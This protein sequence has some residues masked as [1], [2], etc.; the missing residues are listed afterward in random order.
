MS[1]LLPAWPRNPPSPGN[2][3]SSSDPA[4]HQPRSPCLPRNLLVRPLTSPDTRPGSTTSTSSLR[5][6]RIT[7]DL[8]GPLSLGAPRKLSP[9]PLQLQTPG[10]K[11]RTSRPPSK[12]SPKTPSLPP[13]S[14]N[15]SPFGPTP[16][17]EPPPTPA[18]PPPCLEG[19][20]IE[21]GGDVTTYSLD[22][23]TLSND[24]LPPQNLPQ[25]LTEL[26]QCSVP[27]PANSDTSSA[28]SDGPLTNSD[29]FPA[30]SNASP[31]SPEP[32]GPFPCH[33]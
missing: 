28:N 32:L 18:R 1:T 12:D 20:D 7:Q 3:L 16:P 14:P 9:P 33:A 15:Q 11:R 13:R 25:C 26:P 19:L 5:P 17:L 29:V 2:P 8:L 23:H 31:G 4:P 24:S 10:Y 21:R 6:L 22:P 30:V 27:T